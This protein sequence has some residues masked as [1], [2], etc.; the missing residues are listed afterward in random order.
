MARN[1]TRRKNVDWYVCPPEGSSE[2]Y[3]EVRQGAT[4]AVL[5]DIRD[6]LQT[7]NRLL[8]CGNFTGIPQTLKRMDRRLAQ[9]TKLPKGRAKK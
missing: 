5:M 1:D 2:I 4:L 8:H 3:P 9:R 7:L 6:E